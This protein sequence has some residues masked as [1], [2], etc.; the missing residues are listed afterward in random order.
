MAEEA[1]VE[2]CE[3]CGDFYIPAN[4]CFYCP[5]DGGEDC[6]GICNENICTTCCKE[7]FEDLRFPMEGVN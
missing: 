1:K 5:H 6:T 4:K 7:S 3:S 2:K